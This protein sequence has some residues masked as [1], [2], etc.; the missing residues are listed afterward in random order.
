MF[1]SIF[2]FAIFA[3]VALV[4]IKLFL[5]LFGIAI[6]LVMTVLVWAA[7]GLL[8]YLGLR[9]ISPGTADKVREMILGR[10]ADR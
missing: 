7:F 1:R 6:G 3:V 2:G 4:A 8:I 10:P 9:L 5:A